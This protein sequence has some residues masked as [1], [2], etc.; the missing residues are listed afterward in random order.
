[1]LRKLLALVGGESLL[2][3]KTSSDDADKSKPDPDIVKAALKRVG[4]LP[5]HVV[6]IG[7][8]PY[9]I[10]AATRARIRT[11]AFRSGGWETADLTGAV[12]IY[13]GPADLL[14]KFEKS[15]LAAA[16]VESERP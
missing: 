15:L 12:A 11:I 14:A 8:T 1:M 5:E 10:Q 9:D 7:D 6:M 2:D 13:D 4:L 16:A 3:A